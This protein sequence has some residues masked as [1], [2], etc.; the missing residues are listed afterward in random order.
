[1]R[2]RSWAVC[3]CAVWLV[4]LVATKGVAL[5]FTGVNLA[6]ADFGE[7]VLPGTYGT[8]YTYPTNAEIDYFMSK[9]MNTF[10]IPFRWERLQQSANSALNTTELNRL[11]SV[12]KY[13][14]SKG[15]YVLL[16]PHNYARYFP[17]PGDTQGDLSRAVGSAAVPNSAFNDFWTR[18]SNNFKSDN[19]VMFGLMNEPNSMPTEQWRDAAQSAINAI[20]ATGSSNLIMVPG[21]AWT[22]AFS[23]GDNWYGTPN[24]Q[25]MLS[26]TDPGNNFAFEVHQYLDSN[27][28]GGGG[29]VVSATVGRDRL[30]N[31]TNWLHA[32]NR[33]G[34]LGEFAVPNSTIDATKSSSVIGDD[35]IDLML[36]YMQ[37]HR[38]V[39]LGWTWWAAGPWWGEYQLTLEPTNLGQP[40]QADRPAMGLLRSHLAI[41]GDYD[42]NG[43]VDAADY[44]IW[45]KSSGQA[46]TVGTG[47]DGDGNGTIGA[48]D[49]TV[50]RQNLGKSRP[51]YYA[52]PGAG[53]EVPEPGVGG[54]V[55]ILAAW[56]ASFRGRVVSESQ[57]GMATARK[58]ASNTL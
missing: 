4:G 24:A 18:L 39:W 2:L 26:I 29:S 17:N 53:V 16:D 10:R 46:V 56:G 35:A 54:L 19:H 57:G 44:V 52:S 41:S 34:F 36:N 14:T 11:N 33:R 38:D 31:F 45:R 49:Y 25:A 9:G 6:G 30:V 8:N 22:G 55:L 23:W 13:A 37:D 20:R 1:M 43:T 42:G 12:V 58:L 15:A 3:C 21:N 32:N 7:T 47:A 5:S 27:G 48:A 50:W 51:T 28:S 40:S